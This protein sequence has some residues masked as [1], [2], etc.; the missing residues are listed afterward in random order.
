MGCLRQPRHA[1]RLYRARRRHARSDDLRRWHVLLGLQL[2]DRDDH[3]QTARHGLGR[4]QPDH[5]PAAHPVRGSECPLVGLPGDARQSRLPATAAH[6]REHHTAR[7][8]RAAHRAQAPARRVPR[9]DAGYDVRGWPVR[10]GFPGHRCRHATLSAPGQLLC[11]DTRRLLL[12]KA[13]LHKCLA[14]HRGPQTRHGPAGVYC[15][16]LSLCR[17]DLRDLHAWRSRLVRFCDHVRVLPDAGSFS[18]DA[19]PASLDRPQ[20]CAVVPAAEHRNAT[21]R[22]N[23]VDRAGQPAAGRRQG[24]D[25]CRRP[26]PGGRLARARYDQRRRSLADG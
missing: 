19:C 4:G 9:H 26:D 2:A 16:R 25:S 12:G 10:D 1:R 23:A 7:G 6:T 11:H 14:R 20:R 13:V 21:G 22:R 18:R 5:P 8:G 24:P 17:I 3:G 15:R